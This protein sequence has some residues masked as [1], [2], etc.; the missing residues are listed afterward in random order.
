MNAPPYMG[1]WY[2]G[3]E[4]MINTDMNAIPSERNEGEEEDEN[5]ETEGS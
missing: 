1:A 2:P 4:P 5:M 3:M